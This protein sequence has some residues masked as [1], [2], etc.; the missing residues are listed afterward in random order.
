[1]K[2]KVKDLEWLSPDLNPI[3]YVWAELD[4]YV[5][6]REISNKNKFFEMKN[7]KKIS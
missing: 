3:K 5:K 4:R 2:K 6:P 1:M 7:G